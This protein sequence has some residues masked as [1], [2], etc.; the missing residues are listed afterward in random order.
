MDWVAV[1]DGD[2][3]F[4]QCRI[5]PTAA[6]STRRSQY[7]GH[8]RRRPEARHPH[9]HH[10]GHARPGKPPLPL[11]LV[12][13]RSTSRRTTAASS[14]R[15]ARCLLRSLDRGDH[16]QEISPDLST[17]DTA[18]ILPSSEGGLPG[19]IPWF[20]I[21]PIS[22]SPVTPGVIWVGTSDGKVQLTRDNGATW[23]DLT[24]K[25]AAA[26]RPERAV[27]QPRP[28]F[29]LQ[30]AGTAYVTKNGYK[31]D[32]FRPFLYQDRGL[33]RDLDVALR[34]L[35]NE[36]IN[37]VFEDA[38]NPDLL[39]LGNDTGVFVSIDGGKSWVKMNNNMPNVP[40]HDLLVHP[41]ESDLVVG[42]Y[43]RGICSRTSPRSRS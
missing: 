13:A 38:K 25:I 39:F 15:A 4:D 41:R 1:G 42:S 27:R 2:G 28:G 40:V 33:R 10:A 20:A 7:G 36:P 26:G 17:N 24:P 23:T 3:M 18:K 29:E 16:W 8:F 5:R 32:D 43:G 19:G 37:V 12:H 14:T 21:S 11:H 35:P 30:R 34:N 31:F 6:G 9:E 22:E